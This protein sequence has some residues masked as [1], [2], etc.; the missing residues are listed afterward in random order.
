MTPPMARRP[1]SPPH[2][3]DDAVEEILLRL[4][5]DDPASLVRAATVCRSWRRIVLADADTFSARYCAFHGTPPV[6]GFLHRGLVDTNKRG[7]FVPTTTSFHPSNSAALDH[8]KYYVKD[9][10]HGVLLLGDPKSNLQGLSLW[11]PITG[12]QRD[13]PDGPEAVSSRF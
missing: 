13:L 12:D 9:C 1:C 3:V 2:P 10:R 6:L 4:P 8:N 7:L 11:D 5:P